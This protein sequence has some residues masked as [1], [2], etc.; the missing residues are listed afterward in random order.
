[1]SY[2]P[3]ALSGGSTTSLCRP[4]IFVGRSP[5]SAIP[6]DRLQRR[7]YRVLVR[8]IATDAAAQHAAHHVVRQGIKVV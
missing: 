2:M 3:N 5:S 4:L 8:D 7:E 6:C 1:M